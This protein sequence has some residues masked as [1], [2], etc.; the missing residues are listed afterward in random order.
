[1]TD[2]V[3]RYIIRPKPGYEWAFI[4][5]DEKTGVFACYSSFGNYNYCWNHIG[6]RTLKEFLRGLDFDYFM[7]KTRSGYRRF[8]YDA[9]VEGIKHHIIDSRRTAYLSK[10]EARE[11]WKE[12][13]DISDENS[14]DRFFDAFC[15]SKP[16]MHVYGGDICDI[17]RERPDPDSRGFWKV[18]WPT[19]LEKIAQ[20]EGV[21]A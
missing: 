7:G 4:Y 20:T 8:D 2:I 6:T 3:E 18:I 14:S 15:W 21:A 5:V 11:A 19:F 13:D 1:M 16:L 9:T 17:A 12:L 10:E